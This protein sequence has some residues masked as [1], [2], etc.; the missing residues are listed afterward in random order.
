VDEILIRPMRSADLDF[1]AACT[2]AEGWA[3]ETRAQFESHFAHDPSGCLIAEADGAPLGICV[4]TGYG[5]VGFVGELIV[6]P[7]ARGRG[8][9]RRLLDCALDHLHAQGARSIYLDGVVAAVPLYERAGFRKVCR[10]LRLAGE[11]TGCAVPDVRPIRPDEVY[12]VAALDCAAF[13]ADRHG[14][15]ERRLRRYPELCRVAIVDGAPAGLVLGRPAGDW[16]SAGPWIVAPALARPTDLIAALL[17]PGTS[18]RIGMGILETNQPARSAAG[19]LGLSEQPDPP[20]R[21]VHGPD[22]GLGRSLQCYAIGSA[23]KG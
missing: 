23:A 4:A 3:G 11:V 21:M 14:F 9:G 22:A 8:L 16:V 20:W 2:A 7:A 5:D 18:D 13:G 17:P 10:S 6:V 15:L 12:A 19:D 1:A